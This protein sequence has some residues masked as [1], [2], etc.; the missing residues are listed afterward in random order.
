MASLEVEAART[1]PRGAD[2]ERTL[3][4]ENPATGS[5]KEARWWFKVYAEL[6]ELEEQLFND[7]ASNVGRMPRDARNEA[8]ATNLPIIESQLRRFRHRRSYWS[9]RVKALQSE[10]RR[11]KEERRTSMRRLVADR[12]KAKRK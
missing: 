6:T 12:R 7:L 8:M 2:L 10:G 3:V 1:A 11:G 9:S 5:L 4:G